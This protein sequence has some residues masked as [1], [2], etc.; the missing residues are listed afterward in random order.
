[1]KIKSESTPCYSGKA[2]GVSRVTLRHGEGPPEL[3]DNL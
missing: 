2:G 1:M 3:C